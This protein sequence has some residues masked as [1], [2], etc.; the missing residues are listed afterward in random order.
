MRFN[1]NYGKVGLLMFLLVLSGVDVLAQNSQHRDRGNG[2]PFLFSSDGVNARLSSS[3]TR[4]KV[5]VDNGIVQSVEQWFENGEW[6]DDMRTDYS[7]SQDRRTITLQMYSFDGDG[8]SESGSEVLTFN[9]LGYPLSAYSSFGDYEFETEFFYGDDDQID[10]SYYEG[11][12]FNGG[13][14]SEKMYFNF[15]TNDSIRISRIVVEDGEEY[16][17]NSDFM[18]NKDGNFIEFYVESGSVEKYTTY[19]T[20]FNDYLVNAFNQ[21]YFVDYDAEVAES[22]EGPFEPDFRVTHTEENGKVISALEEYY[23]EATQMWEAEYRTEYT[24]HN[25][26]NYIIEENE[27]YNFGDE[28]DNDYRTIYR[29]ASSVTTQP[30]EAVETFRLQQ[31]YPNPFNP[32]TVIGFQ[33]S[34]ASD[35]KITVYDMLGREIAVLLDEFRASG[36]YEVDFDASGLSSGIY[37]YRLQTDS[38]IKSRKMILQK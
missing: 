20:S 1:L 38:F 33:L 3:F 21:F 13:T 8:W 31:N 23:S 19:N 29:Y 14:E 28:W 17:S 22:V 35:V 32:T 36:E 2:K 11:T 18:Y 10:S 37:I 26:T 25:N 6:V 34:E 16:T 24:Y 30:G 5:M 4:A 15:V 7:Y 27:F 9:E 12:T